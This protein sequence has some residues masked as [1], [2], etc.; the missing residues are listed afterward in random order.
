MKVLT[1]HSPLIWGVLTTA[2]SRWNISLLA[3]R[4]LF[5]LLLVAGLVVTF[6]TSAPGLSFAI[7]PYGIVGLLTYANNPY[8]HQTMYRF[9]MIGLTL[10]S[11][12]LV[13]LY[14]L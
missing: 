9:F 10:L 4:L 8:R 1:T 2:A 13:V 3:L 7:I 6:T 14:L 11:V 12:T 5:L